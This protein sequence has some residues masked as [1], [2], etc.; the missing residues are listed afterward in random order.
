MISRRL[1]RVNSYREFVIPPK[2]AF[3]VVVSRSQ[4][5][6]TPR[7]ARNLWGLLSHSEPEN[8]H[9]VETIERS[10]D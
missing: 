1:F 3:E 2:P 4:E 5:L 6:P 9:Y 8:Q 7:R 10:L